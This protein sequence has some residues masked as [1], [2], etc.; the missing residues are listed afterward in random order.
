MPRDRR[1]EIL[2]RMLHIFGNNIPG[3]VSAWRNRGQVIPF[4]PETKAAQLPS[5]VLLDGREEEG[6][7]TL[8]RGMR[9]G[10]PPPTLMKLYPQIFV[11]LMPRQDS[12]NEGVGPELSMYRVAVL[13]QLFSDPTLLQ[14]LGSNGDIRYMGHETDL[15]TGNSLEG[16]MN[17]RMC[18]TYVLNPQEL[19]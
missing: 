14:L 7:S 2:Q 6:P 1:E 16:Q 3:I 19:F 10:P 8:N 17:I 15:A 18:I 9:P 13:G 5:I 12:L 11:V 4:N